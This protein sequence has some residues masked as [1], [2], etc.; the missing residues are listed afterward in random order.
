MIR[1]GLAV[2]VLKTRKQPLQHGVAHSIWVVSIAI[3]RHTRPAAPDV[4]WQI[5]LRSPCRAK[6][7]DIL[8]ERLYLPDRLAVLSTSV[9]VN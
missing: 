1:P 3:S 7:I 4:A 8:P 9:L 2:W 5:T 6:G